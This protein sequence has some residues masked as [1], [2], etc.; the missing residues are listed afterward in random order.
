M[1]SRSPSSS[2]RAVAEDDAAGWEVRAGDELHQVLDRHVLAAVVVVDQVAQRVAHL[3]QVVRR[4]VGRHADGDAAGAVDEQVGQGGGQHERLL[5]GAVEVVAPVDRVLLDVGQHLH[6]DLGQP[7]LGVAHGRRIV[8]VD[9]AE[10]ALPVDERIAQREVLR[11]A[12]HRLVHGRVAVRMV[13]A[14]HL[15][16]DTG[17]LLVRLVGPQPQVV[18]GVQ[19]APVHRLQP[20]AHVGQR[21]R[22]D[23]AHGVVEVRRLHLRFDI[24]LADRS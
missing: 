14:Q 24:D 17:R 18:H 23:H 21:P 11:H 1:S 12:H 20:V 7:R 15:A 2:R 3:A 13:L 9:R 4:D 10:V 5:E 22:H 8:A 19:D 6:G 16:D